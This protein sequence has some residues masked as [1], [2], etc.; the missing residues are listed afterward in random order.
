[1]L[2]VVRFARVPGAFALGEVVL[3]AYD[4]LREAGIKPFAFVCSD[5]PRMVL[6]PKTRQRA[7]A[8]LLAAGFTISET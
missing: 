3:R 2:P 1:M 8:A 7:I 6:A 4:C 5:D